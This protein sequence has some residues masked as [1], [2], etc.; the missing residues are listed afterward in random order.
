MVQE[1]VFL[2]G[3]GVTK[4]PLKGR[5]D[6]TLLLTFSGVA[7]RDSKHM[8]YSQSVVQSDSFFKSLNLII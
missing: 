3:Q 8:Q 6:S 2:A 4:G 7:L 5:C 1:P